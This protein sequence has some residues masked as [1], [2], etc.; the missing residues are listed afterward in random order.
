MSGTKVKGYML[1]IKWGTKLIKGLETSGLKIKPNFEEVLLKGNQGMP[2]L[3]IIDFDMDVSYSGKTY[4]RGS[5]ESATHEDFETLREATSLGGEVS[6]IYG[7]LIPEGKFV[8]GMAQLTDYSEDGNSKDTGSF[9]G[10]FKAKKGTVVF[11]ESWSAYYFQPQTLVV[12]NVSPTKVIMTSSVV[13]KSAI[14]SDFTITGNTITLLERDVTNK[15]LTLTLSI[16]ILVFE[17][18][19]VVTYNGVN[20]DV[21]NNVTDDGNTILWIEPTVKANVLRG[22]DKTESV[23]YDIP[24]KNNF[25][26]IENNGT[27]VKY[28]VYKIITTQ[29]DHFYTGCAINDIFVSGNTDITLDASNTVRKLNGNHLAQFNSN[30]TPICR[31]LQAVNSKKM[32]TAQFTTIAQPF[33]ICATIMQMSWVDGRRIWDGYTTDKLSLVQHPTGNIEMYAGGG[34]VINNPNSATNRIEIIRTVYNGGNSWSQ[35]NDTAKVTG[36]VNSSNME[37]FTFG[38]KGDFT[39]TSDIEGREFIIRK[40]A[41]ATELNDRIYSIMKRKSDAYIADL[42]NTLSD[43]EDIANVI[44]YRSRN[45][46]TEVGDFNGIQLTQ[47]AIG[48]YPAMWIN[49]FYWMARSGLISTTE[50]LNCYNWHKSHTSLIGIHAYFVPEHIGWDGTE[51][52]GPGYGVWSNMPTLG[53]NA[54][55]ALLA[56]LYYDKTGDSAFITGELS[57]LEAILTNVPYNNG[58]VNISVA[59]EGAIGFTWQDALVITGKLA[60]CNVLYYDAFKQLGLI[61]SDLALSGYLFDQYAN[62]I[63]AVW[64]TTFYDGTKI[65]ASTGKCS[66]QFDIIAA[67]YAVYCGLADGT[68]KTNIV[69]L[70]TTYISDLRYKGYIAMC[71]PTFF[72]AADQVFEEYGIIQEFGVMQNGGY[73][74]VW[75]PLILYTLKDIDRTVCLDILNDAVNEIMLNTDRYSVTEWKSSTHRSTVDN[76]V[77]SITS[78]YEAVKIML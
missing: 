12:E 38:S 31:M 35:V 6:F 2:V 41:D 62:G 60:S 44:I 21:T 53:S 23:W 78:L 28:G 13:N 55:L 4:E 22:I 59:N 74:L 20:Y 66:G 11:Y 69:S 49:D 37:A 76:Y 30:E 8:T 63:K 43:I 61:C 3:E 50:M 19:L 16:P 32:K 47:P 77:A 71:P 18:D 33:S 52:W 39:E 24:N 57:F 1:N 9:S 27:T 65:K 48:T 75:L 29:A 7:T 10:S 42:N 15:I 64:G 45:T 72:Y 58:L 68:L 26:S 70:L 56:C 46:I 51:Y 25:G 34:N 54:F 14:A 17:D 5:G 73:F 67:S 36:T 40:V